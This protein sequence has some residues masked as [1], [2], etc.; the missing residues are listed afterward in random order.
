MTFGSTDAPTVSIGIF[1][2]GRTYAPGQQ[3]GIHRLVI[4]SGFFETMGI[5]VTQGREFTSRDNET[6]LHVLEEVEERVPQRL[7]P[8]LDG[9]LA[10]QRRRS[11]GRSSR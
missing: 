6:A 3:D 1:V 4:S 2:Q 8:Q 11:N 10:M 9:F 5:K 7:R